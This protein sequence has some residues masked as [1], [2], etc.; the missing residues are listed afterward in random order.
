MI[1]MKK[2]LPVSTMTTVTIGTGPYAD[3][4]TVRTCAIHGFGGYGDGPARVTHLAFPAFGDWGD[5]KGVEIGLQPSDG[6][7][8]GPYTVPYTGPYTEG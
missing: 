5:F 6:V 4:Y 1:A 7:I 3:P 2:N 8:T